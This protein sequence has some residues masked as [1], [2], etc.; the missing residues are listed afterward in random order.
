MADEQQNSNKRVVWN[1]DD[2]PPVEKPTVGIEFFNVNSGE[3]KVCNTEALI[4]AF[5]NS[6]NLHVNAMVG[7]DLGWRLAAST[8][9]RMREIRE[10]EAA[11]QRIVTRFRLTEEADITD[12]HLLTYMFQEDLKKAAKAEEAEQGQFARQYE[13]E[14]RALDEEILSDN[15]PPSTELKKVVQPR[16]SAAE[17]KTAQKQVADARRREENI[18]AGRDINDG[19]DMSAE[20]KALVDGKAEKP[21]ANSAK[22]DDNKSQ[23]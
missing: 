8:V 19:I 22:N 7:Q 21:V 11:M 17:R 3:K 6:S 4:T 16:L 15:T 10:D 9:K 23:S 13:E 5:Y 14:I 12:P 20:E 2:F 18:A 1:K